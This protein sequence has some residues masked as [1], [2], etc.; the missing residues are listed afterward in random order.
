MEALGRTAVEQPASSV[1]QCA[2]TCERK[3]IDALQNESDTA[4]VAAAVVRWRW[5]G[6]MSCGGRCDIMRAV[7]STDDDE[8]TLVE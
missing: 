7:M 8:C 2:R 5:R 6:V 1:L 4:M 3:R